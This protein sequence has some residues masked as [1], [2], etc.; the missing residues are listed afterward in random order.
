MS[1]SLLCSEG[2]RK[3]F[4]GSLLQLGKQAICLKGGDI[5]RIAR[6]VCYEV[7]REAGEPLIPYQFDP[8]RHVLSDRSFF[9]MLGFDRVES[10]DASDFEGADHLFDL[11]AA[12]TPAPLCDAFDVILDGGTME[13]VF[14]I[15]HFLANLHRMLKVGGRLISFVPASNMVE[16]GFY[17]FSPCLFVDWATANG[18]EISAL[19]LLKCNGADA[20]PSGFTLRLD[21]T[22]DA[23]VLASLSRIGGLDG[24]TY[25]L[26]SVLTRMAA[27]T[28]TAIP[29]Q[30]CYA[31][32]WAGQ[33][34]EQ[35]AA[36]RRVFPYVN[37]KWVLPWEAVP[38]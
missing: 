26:M 22:A 1:A 23:D 24:D 31:R 11:N 19:N 29:I 28:G 4:Q 14:H 8:S 17:S 7:R 6:A 34:Q 30:G 16:H 12:E 25:L 9:R 33:G 36:A 15:P 13:H 3:T 37:G 38:C 32:R 35:A 21:P 10:L 27:S 20:D 5:D 18:Y 2:V